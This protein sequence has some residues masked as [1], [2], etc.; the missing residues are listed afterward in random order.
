MAKLALLHTAARADTPEQ[1]ERR[2]KLIALAEE[3]RLMEVN[4]ALWPVL[5]HEQRQGDTQLRAIVDAML[6]ETGAEVFVR[7]SK[8]LIARI[9]SRPTLPTIRSPALVI[10]GEGDRITPI[11]ANKEI[12][13]AIPGAQLE[14]ITDCGHLSTLEQPEAVTKHLVNWFGA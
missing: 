14:I 7:Q 10:V 6:I 4:D 1:T 3:G 12:A 5:V 9:D 11:A 13:G 2:P 8:A